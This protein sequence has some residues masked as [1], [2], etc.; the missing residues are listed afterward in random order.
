[1]FNFKFQTRLSKSKLI[2]D[3]GNANVRKTSAES[4]ISHA[5]LFHKVDS[6]IHIA[7]PQFMTAKRKQ[8][9]GICFLRHLQRKRAILPPLQLEGVFDI[10][11]AHV[12]G[13]CA[14]L[15][16][17]DFFQEAILLGFLDSTAPASPIG[18]TLLLLLP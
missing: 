9:A 12:N 4:S 8:S 16:R 6:H 7:I 1:M 3:V 18:E 17:V 15:V 11:R 10:P 5:N 13:R 14:I 2:K